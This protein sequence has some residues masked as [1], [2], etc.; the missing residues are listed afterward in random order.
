M[1][2]LKRHLFKGSQN[3]HYNHV[4]ESLDHGQILLHVECAESYKNSQQNEIQSAY[5]GNSTFSIFAAC[6][7]TK[8]LDNGGLKKDS[9]V[10][11][12]DSKEHNRAAALTCLKKVVEKAEEIN[13]AKYDKIIVWSDGCSAQFRSRFVFC[14]LTEYLFDGFELMWNFLMVSSSRGA[15]QKKPWKGSHGRCKRDREKH[16]LPYSQIG[17]CYDWFTFRVPSSHIEICPF[18][19]TCLFTWYSCPECPENIEQES[20]KI[21]ETLKVHHVERFEVKGVHGFKCFYL[22][23]DEQPFYTQWYSNRKDAVICR[24]EIADVDDNHCALCLEKYSKEKKSG[25]SVRDCVS[26]GITN[27]A[28]SISLL[29]R[30]FLLVYRSFLLKWFFFVGRKQYFIR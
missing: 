29:F 22:A 4:K 30:L 3:R 24:H 11:V 9:V 19:K 13:L 12:N 6:C 28:F 1:V 8:W 26:S 5:L 20:K 17:L 7:Y 16:H 18:D 27:S 10:L 21:P 15:T 23:E 2:S 25:Y 14:L